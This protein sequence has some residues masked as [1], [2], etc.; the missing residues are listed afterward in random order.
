MDFMKETY[1][2]AIQDTKEKYER[3][4][5]IN[6]IKYQEHLGTYTNQIEQL[7][8]E[9]AEIKGEYIEEKGV[10]VIEEESEEYREEE[11]EEFDE[12]KVQRDLIMHVEDPSDFYVSPPS[13]TPIKIIEEG[14]QK[15]QRSTPSYMLQ[16]ILDL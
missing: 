6:K 10:Q 13:T 4:I 3:E 16:D 7:M 11:D 2:Q 9:M 8:K 15:Q 1:E 5:K 14:E 12:K